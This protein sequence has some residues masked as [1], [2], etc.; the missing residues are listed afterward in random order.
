MKRALAA[1]LLLTGCA[2]TPP[3][4]FVTLGYEAADALVAGAH[5]ELPPD[6]PIVYSVFTP[7]GEPNASSPF[8]RIFAEHVSSGLAHKGLE[9]VELRLREAIAV[10]QG[11]PYALSDNFQD[12]AHRALARAVLVGSYA[13]SH[14][15]SARSGYSNYLGYAGYSGSSDLYYVLITIR[16][17]DASTGIVLS[18][19]DKRVALSRADQALF[20]SLKN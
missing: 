18:S 8:G 20:E 1:L 14:G 13:L 3:N 6:S 16:L 17:V 7:A 9:V 11:G 2:S 5:G 4:D 19:W 15:T 10:R 12:V